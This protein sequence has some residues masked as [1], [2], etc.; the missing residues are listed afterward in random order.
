MNEELKGKLA[1]LIHELHVAINDTEAVLSSARYYPER[2]LD[3]DREM[4]TAIDDCMTAYKT[5]IQ[6]KD[7]WELGKREIAK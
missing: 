1:L 2:T 7:I 6:A 5:M 4:Q 3:I